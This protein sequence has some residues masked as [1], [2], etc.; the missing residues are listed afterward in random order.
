MW[1]AHPLGSHAARAARSRGPSRP[2]WLR[3]PSSEW[4]RCAIDLAWAERRR[5]WRVRRD[6]P[7]RTTRLMRA[8]R[9]AAPVEGRSLLAAG[10]RLMGLRHTV[11]DARSLFSSVLLQPHVSVVQHK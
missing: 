9:P 1:A 10:C 5:R 7:A 11:I 4:A 2:R 6:A 3:H 8:A